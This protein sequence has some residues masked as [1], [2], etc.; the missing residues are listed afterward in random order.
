MGGAEVALNRLLRP[1]P[2]MVPITCR[3]TRSQLSP[4][5]EDFSSHLNCN[6]IESEATEESSK[7]SVSPANE[8]NPDQPRFP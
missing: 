6:T 4:Q 8:L 5:A 1:R 7:A 3:C 2:R